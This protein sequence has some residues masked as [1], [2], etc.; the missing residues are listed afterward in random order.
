MLSS[1][2]PKTRRMGMREPR[3][4]LSPQSSVGQAGVIGEADS[5]RS[6]DTGFG[7]SYRSLRTPPKVTTA[8]DGSPH[9][10]SASPLASERGIPLRAYPPGDLARLFTDFRAGQPGALARTISMVENERLGS[11]SLLRADGMEPASPS[12]RLG[13]TGPPGAGKSTLVN[14]L[15]AVLLERGQSVGVLAVDPTSPYSGGALLGDR[16]RISEFATEGRFFFRSMASR[17]SSGGLGAAA[18]E[19][20]EVMDC[21]G[22]DWLIVETVGAGQTDTTVADV[23]ETVVT[24]LVPESGDEIQALKA[25]L[26]EA[27]DILLV[28]KAD[29][30]GANRMASDLRSM[31]AFQSDGLSGSSARVDTWDRPVILTDAGA[32]EGIGTLCEQID[33]HRTHLELSGDL[34]W[35]AS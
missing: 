14:Q 25:G 16:T 32:G 5:D 27:A 19:A 33:R 15:A 7:P 12:A 21:F 18:G 13:I 22:F 20:L 28:N 17:G 9:P 3:S 2:E 29:R 23:T 8:F 11:D 1:D 30:P 10:S 4:N 6:I 34:R 26:V 35:E 24:L 31:L